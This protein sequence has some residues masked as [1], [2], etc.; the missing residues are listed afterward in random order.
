MNLPEPSPKTVGV[1]KFWMNAPNTDDI[2]DECAKLVD[3]K[4]ILSVPSVFFQG[5]TAHS[6][7]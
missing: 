7:N 4:T 1:P 2:L 6:S 3:E 5:A